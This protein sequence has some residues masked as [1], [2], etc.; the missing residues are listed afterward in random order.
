MNSFYDVS[1][2][3]LKTE[4]QPYKK[5]ILRDANQKGGNLR[6]LEKSCV[7]CS[8]SLTSLSG[9]SIEKESQQC[10]YSP[11]EDLQ[12]FELKDFFDGKMR[13][14]ERKVC[15]IEES[16]VFILFFQKALEKYRINFKKKEMPFLYSYKK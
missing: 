5:E 13:Y 3:K 4:A 9:G 6:S 14:E 12:I 1:L 15:V 7:D 2:D 16:L 8:H 11:K 10:Y